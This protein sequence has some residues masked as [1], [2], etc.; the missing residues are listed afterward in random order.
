[1]EVER[2][3]EREMEMEMEMETATASRAGR[4]QNA[5]CGATSNEQP[6]WSGAPWAASAPP[7]KKRTPSTQVGGVGLSGGWGLS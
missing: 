2:E 4:M 5:E 1:M 6:E 7:P 3:V